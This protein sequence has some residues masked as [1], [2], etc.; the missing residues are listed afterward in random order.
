MDA[1]LERLAICG[2]IVDTYAI[3]KFPTCEKGIE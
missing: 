1:A 2:F 3:H